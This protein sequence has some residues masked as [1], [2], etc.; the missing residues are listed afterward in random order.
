MTSQDII[1]I[2]DEL[3]KKFGIVIDWTAENVIPYLQDAYA[4]L[5]KYQII[6]HSVY[7]FI[8]LAFFV[9]A[10]IIVTKTAKAW[11]KGI[12][13]DEDNWAYE[14][15]YDDLTSLAITMLVFSITCIVISGVCLSINIRTLIEWVLIPEIQTFEMIRGM[16]I[17]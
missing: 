4:R 2:I 17:C 6:M 11:Y 14:S 9:S 12:K 10:I 16:S 3:C 13:N 1:K 8:S 5:I 15:D 7:S